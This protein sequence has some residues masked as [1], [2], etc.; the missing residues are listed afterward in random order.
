[1]RREE[2]HPHGG[3]RE[4]LSRSERRQRTG[5]DGS[6]G[7]RALVRALA[8]GAELR[9]V[10][11]RPGRDTRQ[12][13]AETEDGPPG[14]RTLIA[15]AGGESL[16]TDLGT[17][18]RES[19][20]AAAALA[21]ASAGADADASQEPAT[22]HYP[23]RRN[24]TPERV[25][26]Q[27]GAGPVRVARVGTLE[28]AATAGFTGTAG[29]L[30]PQDRGAECGDSASHG[31]TAGG[32]AAD[33]PSWRR[34][35]HRPGLCADPGSSGS[36]SLRQASRQLSGTDPMR[37][38]Q[39]RAPTARPHQQARQHP[40]AFLADRVGACPRTLRSRLAAVP[41]P[42]DASRSSH[43]Q[44]RDGPKAGSTPVLDVAQGMGSSTNCE[45]RFARGIARSVL[46]C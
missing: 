8:G 6:D 14:C 29:P 15:V 4:L 11:W 16:S 26:E 20:S 21:S 12:T 22:G 44:G 39:W 43:C 42:G 30:A 46:W 7:A 17:E 2:T 41:A 23:E 33:D 27:A 18:S 32:A 36:V 9:A 1:M 25:V 5:G 13:G 45:V 28:Y 35:D 24:T 34:S 19:R 31:R 37:G 38:I 40:L 3:S 10:D